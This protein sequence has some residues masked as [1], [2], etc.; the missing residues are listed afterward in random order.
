MCFL[1][2]CL[3]TEDSFDVVRFRSWPQQNYLT[4]GRAAEKV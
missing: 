3:I 1:N 4:M 2:V